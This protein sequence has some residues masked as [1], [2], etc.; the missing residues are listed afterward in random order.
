MAQRR[1]KVAAAVA[2]LQGISEVIYQTPSSELAGVVGELD[3]LRALAEA[4]LVVATAE[5]E[6][7]GVINE[8]QFASTAGWIRDAAWHLQSGGSG[9]VAKCV[10]ILRRHDLAVLAEAIQTTD[11][12]PT[13]AAT[14]AAEFDKISPDLADGAGPVV[15]DKMIG[16]GAD[17][18]PR[19]VKELRQ[20]LLAQHGLDGAFQDEQDSK[21]RY[22]DLSGG[23]EEN[24]VFHYELTL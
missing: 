17:H 8:S 18:G 2:T 11:V 15:L 22:V 21:H 24:G 6:Q 19:S 13:V 20:L 12:T 4:G 3:Q 9:V 5:A 16:M 1:A 7:R 23:R 10:T 14:I